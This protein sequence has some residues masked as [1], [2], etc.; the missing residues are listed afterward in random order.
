ME[1]YQRHIA[2]EG[3]GLNGQNTL[4]NTS[5]LII[6][7]GGLGVPIMQQLT[8]SG[9]GTIGLMDGD[10]VAQSNLPRQLLYD[11]Q[12]VDKMKVDVAYQKLKILNSE[13][14]FNI[15]PFFLN[16]EKALELFPKYDIIIDAT[17]RFDARYLINDVCVLLQKSWIYGAVS[18]WEG[19]WS[20]F[21]FSNE[22]EKTT[23]RDLFP[24]P[25]KTGLMPDCNSQGI[26]ATVPLLVGFFMANEL[27][28]IL[29]Y[30]NEL[31]PNTLF[32]YHFLNNSQHSLK[33]K[34][35]SKNSSF[36]KTANEILNF[37]YSFYCGYK[38]LD[39]MQDSDLIF[40][41]DEEVTIIDVRQTNE[42][43]RLPMPCLE[44]PLQELPTRIDELKSKKILFVCQ[45]GKRSK[46]AYE[47]CKSLLPLKH[48]NY[49][50]KSIEE[51]L[52][53]YHHA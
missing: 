49:Y 34:P 30:P 33:I 52:N 8:A 2:I 13:V 32:Y 31:Q 37:D 3:F 4:K 18:Q 46:V 35:L 7:A 5:I 40:P 17:D 50:S 15:Y 45:S 27:I 6:G 43:P 28:K 53:K 39:Y 38:S 20:V 23:Y 29:I 21:N 22:N 1:R 24:F 42:L 9:F 25:P 16:A 19:Q 51:F 11:E 47:L 41:L 48:L 36:P 10:K 12:D 14:N 44:I 26:Y